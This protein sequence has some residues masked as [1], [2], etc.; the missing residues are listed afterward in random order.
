MKGIAMEVFS[1]SFVELYS[2]V[3][4]YCI[5]WQAIDFGI[6]LAKSFQKLNT[7]Q[8]YTLGV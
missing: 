7:V 1:S 6:G 4:N 8:K 3:L 2:S 5:I